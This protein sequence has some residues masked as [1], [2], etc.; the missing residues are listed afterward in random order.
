MLQTPRTPYPSVSSQS[1]EIQVN[2]DGSTTVWF[3]PEPPPGMESNWVQT[4][5]GKGWFTIMRLY[6]P[7]EAWFDGT[8]KP[9]EIERVN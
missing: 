8:W 7:L 2:P 5:P 4:V 6:G 1:G 9:G 3:G